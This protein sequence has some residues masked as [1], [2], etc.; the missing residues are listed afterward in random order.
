MTRGLRQLVADDWDSV[1]EQN[2]NFREDMEI[3]EK[4]S[5]IGNINPMS[6]K[7]IEEALE[8]M[9]E[10]KEMVDHPSHYNVAGRKECIVEMEELFGI[11]TCVVFAIMNAYKYEYRCGYKDA[12]E[13]EK[14]KIRWY[15]EY[16][17]ANVKRCKASTVALYNK[18]WLLKDRSEVFDDFKNFLS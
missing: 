8:K 6:H 2:P 16:A 11:D 13:Q 7:E 18:Y 1:K 9:S 14:K 5:A 15:Q 12:E 3:I 17:A 10:T 4:L